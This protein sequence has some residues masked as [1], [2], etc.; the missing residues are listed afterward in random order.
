M[1]QALRLP[2]LFVSRILPRLFPGL[3]LLLLL[4]LWTSLASAQ[5]ASTPFRARL[6][7]AKT[8]LD[9]IE[10]T[11]ARPILEDTA[12]GR[13]REQV[14]APRADLATLQMDV[15]G[16]RDATRARLD[17]LGGPPKPGE[18]PESKDITEA[19]QREQSL[20]GNLDGIGKEAQAQV[21]RADQLA[22]TITERRRDAFTQQLT[23]RSSSIAD[24]FFWLGTISDLPRAGWS[25]SIA[26]QD[27]WTYFRLR[28]G[29]GP[30]SIALSILLAGALVGRLGRAR[31]AHWRRRRAHRPHAQLR[32]SAS[33][34][35]VLMVLH[36]ML[37]W[38]L[39]ALTVLLALAIPDLCPER[40]LDQI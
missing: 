23:E 9:T 8:Q 31:I 30:A 19:R 5:D 1:L 28:I 21:V 27:A 7:E 12:L 13:L 24:P 32:L 40:V 26:S 34:E 35:V 6:M 15:T 17:Q 10:T 33:L 25:L 39:A 22:N 16:P 2:P 18:P 14:D 3:L 29:I 20:F 4:P 38:P 37:G 11:L 36:A